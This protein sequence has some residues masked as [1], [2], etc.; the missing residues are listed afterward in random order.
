MAWKLGRSDD[1]KMD[2]LWGMGMW[3]LEKTISGNYGYGV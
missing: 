1:W 3:N 2:V